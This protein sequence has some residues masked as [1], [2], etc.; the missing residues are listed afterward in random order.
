MAMETII[1]IAQALVA[2][3]G[4]MV[5]ASNNHYE[6]GGIIS[7]FGDG[8]REESRIP[9]RVIRRSSSEEF[10]RQSDLWERLFPEDGR[11]KP[12]SLDFFYR[13][14]AAD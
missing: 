12:F 8:G 13:V 7:I 2:E 5:V 6:D 1:D 4:F 11:G 3:Q 10:M 14:I 9:L